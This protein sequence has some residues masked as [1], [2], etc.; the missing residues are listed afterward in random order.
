MKNSCYIK[1]HLWQIPIKTFVKVRAVICAI[2]SPCSQNILMVSNNIIAVSGYVAIYEKKKIPF[3][4]VTQKGTSRVF[5]L[6]KN[7]SWCHSCSAQ[8]FSQ[9]SEDHR[10]TKIG[11]NIQII[12]FNHLP[13][14]IMPMI[15]ITAQVALEKGCDPLWCPSSGSVTLVCADRRRWNPMFWDT[16][17]MLWD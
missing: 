8:L 9:A 13:I 7:I 14:S 4:V 6:G 5:L 16:T 11:E 10:I 2:V 1:Q 3:S 12:Q 15:R 17:G